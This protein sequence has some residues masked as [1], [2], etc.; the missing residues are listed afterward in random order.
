MSLH[1]AI[2]VGRI[3]HRRISPV[4]HQLDYPIFMP[5]IELDSIRSLKERVFLF[6]ER[7]WNWARFKRSDYLGSGDLISD[8]LSKA[9]ELHGSKVNGNVFSLCHLRYL[10]FYFSPVNFY[11]IFEE[12][13]EL[14]TKM[15]AEVSNTP[16]NQRNYY[17]VPLEK[18]R[19]SG[20]TCQKH[21][22]VSPFNPIE[23]TYVWRVAIKAKQIVIHL[24]CHR[25]DKEFD[26]TLTL[27][28]TPFTSKQWWSLLRR[29][30][31]V[32]VSTLWGI[33]WHA[34]KLWRKGAPVYS[35]PDK[36]RTRR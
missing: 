8:V 19:V 32:A 25:D 13:S 27:V 29:T 9:S 18:G 4:T 36:L 16:W 34:F 5:L 1:S 31:I 21:F 30:P 2:M 23:Q 24:E 7:W 20:F 6:G 3:R 35:H 26:A 33:Y 28:P 14:P 17:L 10:G 15:L 22:H 12:S 11:F